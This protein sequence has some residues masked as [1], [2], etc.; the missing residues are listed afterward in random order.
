MHHTYTNVLGMDRD[1][2]YGVVRMSQNQP[3]R[4]RD[5]GNPIYATLLALLFEWGVAVHDLEFE[6]IQSG[7]CTLGDKRETIR[8]I[9]RKGRGQLVKDYVAFPAL[10]GRGAKQVLTAN[11]TANLIRNVWAFVIIFCGHFPDGVAEFAPDLIEGETR[12]EWYLRQMLGSADIT[13]GPA[14]HLLSGNLGFQ[15]EHHLFPDIPAHRYT[16]IAARVR[17]ICVRYRLPYN[18]G[19]L[20]RQFGSVVRK[21]WRLSLPPRGHIA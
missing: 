4:P 18:A 12:G 10:A 11:L 15:I 5:L 21:L 3:W 13:G 20:G 19:P 17:E 2:G 8:E 9:L 6:R 14:F 7:E 1:I 16:E